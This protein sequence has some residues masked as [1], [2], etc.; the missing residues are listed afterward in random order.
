MY[1]VLQVRLH[2]NRAPMYSQG[3]QQTA[4]N[5]HSDLFRAGTAKTT[6]NRNVTRPVI[7][8]APAQGDSRTH[9]CGQRMEMHLGAPLATVLTGPWVLY[10]QAIPHTTHSQATPLTYK[11]INSTHTGS[12]TTRVAADTK[13]T[14]MCMHCVCCCT[15][16]TAWPDNMHVRARPQR[17]DT[18]SPGRAHEQNHC[19]HTFGHT[20]QPPAIYTATQV[21][22]HP[23]GAQLEHQGRSSGILST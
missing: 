2:N 3:V 17:H 13:G 22:H 21:G 11:H 7:E 8:Y 15:S 19:T 9:C 1:Q 10:S 5:G 18:D 16:A 12:Q 23:R 4:S 20:P 6:A 14:W